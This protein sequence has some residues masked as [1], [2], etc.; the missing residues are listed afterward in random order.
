MQDAFQAVSRVASSRNGHEVA[1]RDALAD[2]LDE[3]HNASHEYIDFIRA[4]CALQLGNLQVAAASLLRSINRHPVQGNKFLVLADLMG[5]LGEQEEQLKFLDVAQQI[6]GPNSRAAVTEVAILRGKK[7]YAAAFE[8]M[9]K[10][11]AQFPNQSWLWLEQGRLCEEMQLYGLAVAAYRCLCERIPNW[12]AGY[13]RLLALY[14]RGKDLASAQALLDGLDQGLGDSPDRWCIR[15]FWAS[16][17]RDWTGVQEFVARCLEA[18]PSHTWAHYFQAA[19][20][21]ETGRL[22]EAAAVW[23]RVIEEADPSDY[24]WDLAVAALGR[25]GRKLEDVTAFEAAFRRAIE[26]APDSPALWSAVADFYRFR[27]R[28]Q[29]AGQYFDV[30]YQRVTDKPGLAMSAGRLMLHL[31]LPAE[32]RRWFERVPPH[33]AAYA[34]AVH[35]VVNSLR[36]ENRLPE[37]LGLLRQTV[38]RTPSPEMY[39]TLIEVCLDSYAAPEACRWPRCASRLSRLRCRRPPIAWCGP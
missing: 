35:G 38:E 11:I 31:H 26:V 5:R 22:Q 10:T 12:S 39:S 6:S 23:Q 8:L 28:G 29:D 19:A 24:Y 18:A 14:H 3:N 20:L 4:R 17:Q 15:A 25:L 30:L 7:D 32:A 27:G 33:H 21:E 9:D 2:L 1:R 16:L 34:Q 13:T 37:V 36:G